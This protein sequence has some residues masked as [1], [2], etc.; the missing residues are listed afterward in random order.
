[1]GK[2]RPKKKISARSRSSRRPSLARTAV[3]AAA[4]AWRSHADSVLLVLGITHILI[5]LVFLALLGGAF[6]P[7][8]PSQPF[9]A[10]PRERGETKASGEENGDRSLSPAAAAGYGLYSGLLWGAA[11]WRRRAIGRRMFRLIAMILTPGTAFIIVYVIV[12]LAAGE[13]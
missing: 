1:M 3:R 13:S 8:P 7:Q 10:T 6:A 2:R 5:F 11:W 12:R 4:G 9:G